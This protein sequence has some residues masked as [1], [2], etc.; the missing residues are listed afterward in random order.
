MYTPVQSG[1]GY[2]W[3][4]TALGSK[5]VAFH[6]GGH[7]GFSSVF[8]RIPE[9]NRAIVILCNIGNAEPGRLAFQ[10]VTDL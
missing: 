1:Y 7:L 8:M 5:T 9:D 10:I 4:I 2:G 3:A 6:F